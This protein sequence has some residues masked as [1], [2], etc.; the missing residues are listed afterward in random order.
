MSILIQENPNAY[1]SLGT[2]EANLMRQ[3]KRILPTNYHSDTLEQNC[4]N[5]LCLPRNE[6]DKLKLY[7]PNMEEKVSVTS[8]ENRLWLMC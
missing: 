5:L 1:N 7:F 2:E 6:L 4:K 3:V 8:D